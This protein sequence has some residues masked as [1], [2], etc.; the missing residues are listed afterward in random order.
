MLNLCL[1]SAKH[2]LDFELKEPQIDAMVDVTSEEGA[3]DEEMKL[4]KTLEKKV[5]PLKIKLKK[6]F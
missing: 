5:C 3:L 6:L 1:V 2:Y 4:L